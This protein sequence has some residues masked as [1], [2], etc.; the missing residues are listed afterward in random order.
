M[1]TN[2]EKRQLKWMLEEI[3]KEGQ[4]EEWEF[5][6]RLKE[7]YNES[8]R[9]PIYHRWKLFKKY[10]DVK[11]ELFWYKN[12]DKKCVYFTKLTE[13]KYKELSLAIDKLSEAQETAAEKEKE[14]EIQKKKDKPKLIFTVGIPCS[15]KTTWAEKEIEALK[16]KNEDAQIVSFDEVKIDCY[17]NLQVPHRNPTIY[18]IM[19]GFVDAWI[20]LE[21]PTIIEGCNLEVAYRNKFLHKHL[22]PCEPCVKFFDCKPEE[23]KARIKAEPEKHLPWTDEEI[24][25][26]YTL[27]LREKKRIIKSE[28]YT[29]L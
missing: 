3:I 22:H 25:G 9:N 13:E 7:R 12:V 19:K 24:D 1:I 6:R 17:G 4:I 26:M 10:F 23:A 18:G 15:G 8:S 28:K 20:R 16:K 27:Y 11:K 14:K 21:Y 2:D 5:N 29:I